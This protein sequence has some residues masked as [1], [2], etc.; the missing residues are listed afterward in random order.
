M[1][2]KTLWTTF[3]KTGS[4]VDYLNYKGIY[5]QS[6]QQKVGERAVESIDKSDRNG[7]IR[8]TYR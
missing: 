8:D 3:K 4:I 7:A 5:T 6:E 2:D 1:E